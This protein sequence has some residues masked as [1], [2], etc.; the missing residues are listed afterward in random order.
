MRSAE[1]QRDRLRPVTSRGN[2]LVKALRQAATRGEASD[3]GWVALEGVRLV[4]EALRSGLR[5]RAI[6]FRESAAAVAKRLLPQV[7][8]KTE[9]LMLPDEVFAGAS[10]TENPQGVAALAEPRKSS[11]EEMLKGDSP[12]IMAAAG[13]QD[14]GNLGSMLRS[15]E[16]FGASGALLLEGTVSPFNAKVLRA[17]AGSLFRLPVVAM[18][19]SA[20]LAAMRQH[21]VRLLVTSSHKGTPLP[22]TD[23]KGPLCIFI[24]NE[25]AGVPRQIA[26][27]VDAAVVIPHSRDVESLNAGVAASIVLYE[28][29]RQRRL[30]H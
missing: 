26:D 12:L 1:I 8:A 9:A 24:G 4:E 3:D 29:A 7:S 21:Q 20:A 22:E 13:V 16:A 30:A 10:G 11:L 6:F 15:A 27:A 19:A 28:A 23:L 18:K 5:L 17:A 14:P 2:A 25:G